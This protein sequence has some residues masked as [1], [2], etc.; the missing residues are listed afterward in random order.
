MTS[1]SSV[2]LASLSSVSMPEL[3]RHPF[4]TQFQRGVSSLA[5]EANAP[6][7]K[8]TLETQAIEPASTSLTKV[9]GNLGAAVGLSAVM[10]GLAACAVVRQAGR[11][12]QRALK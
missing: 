1:L 9:V 7:E 2:N 8:A 5:A 6:P 3:R 11:V 4:G 10:G 12:A